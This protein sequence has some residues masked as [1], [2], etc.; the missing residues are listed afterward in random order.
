MHRGGRR[1]RGRE[2]ARFRKTDDRS[3]FDD[4]EITIAYAVMVLH[5]CQIAADEADVVLREEF[6]TIEFKDIQY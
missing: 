1:C 6:L 4:P 2:V 5:T 3:A